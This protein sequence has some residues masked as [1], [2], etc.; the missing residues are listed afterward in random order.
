M[1]IRSITTI[2][3][4]SALA[5]PALATI[6]EGDVF[7]SLSGGQLSTGLIT[8][9]GSTITPGVRVFFAEF[10]ADAPNITDEP[11]VQ[12]LPAGLGSA[13][14]FRFDILKAV[15]KWNG[16][17]F[18]TIAAESLTADL[19]PLSV[20]S[21]A[22]DVFTPGF[23]IPLDATGSHEHPDWTLNAPASNG[24]YLLE[25]QWELNTGQVSPFTW[26]IFSQNESEAVNE[27]AY[28]WAVANVPTPGVAG[29]LALG[30]L[31]A[32]RRRR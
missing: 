17:N 15:R 28:D 3:A 5:A 10:G 20:T 26:M 29:V 8:E 9:D 22:T 2:I 12:S 1:Q 4:L 11:G 16:V 13:T 14:S 24:V 7:L 18:S 23:S 21:P 32:L 30:G 31:V 27:A 19:G 25:V 6:P